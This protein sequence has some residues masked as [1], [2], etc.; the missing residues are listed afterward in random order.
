M[1]A[2]AEV[3]QKCLSHVFEHMHATRARAL[4]KAV[5]ALLVC[6]RLILMDLARAWPGADRVRAPLKCLDRLLSNSHLHAQREAIYAEMMGW[7]IRTP[8]PIILVD[9]SDLHGDCRWQLLR[10]AVPM[11][12]RTITLLDMVFPESM[13]GAPKAER[14]L[15]ERLK[16][17]LP[18][19]VTPILVTDAGF[20][21]PWFR[22]VAQ[23]GWQ[24]V[25]RLRNRT[26]IKLQGGRWM[27]NRKLLPT[28]GRTPQRLNSAAMVASNPLQ[29]DL[30]LYRKKRAGRVQLNRHGTAKRSAR[31][32]KAQRRERDPWLLVASTGLG[33]LSAKQI[34]EIYAKRM[35]IEE[36]FRDLKCER[37][38]CGFY[39]SLTRKPERIAT[40]LL[41]HSLAAFATWLASLSMSEKA[42]QHYGGVLGGRTRRHYSVFRIAWEALKRSDPLCTLRAL[43]NAFLHPPDSFFD[44]L[45][46]PP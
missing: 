5:Q 12:G 8:S 10:A 34:V 30:V 13:K 26:Q 19:W 2:A 16:A 18:A 4:I 6:R 9:W 28:A 37:F 36:S 46:V 24:Y 11:G 41:I 45:R 43:F 22:A 29:V 14:A 31:G 25:G 40:L 17:L 15:L 23:M 20:R 42:S 27:N 38:G 1:P 21:A 35:Q 32:L 33:Q 39:Y 44:N 7:L 3:L